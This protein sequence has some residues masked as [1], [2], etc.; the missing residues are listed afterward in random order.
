MNTTAMSAPVQ[1]R[2]GASPAVSTAR[3]RSLP[4][5]PCSARPG[6]L[7]SGPGPHPRCHLHILVQ[8]SAVT[9]SPVQSWDGLWTAQHNHPNSKAGGRCTHAA[10]ALSPSIRTTGRTDP[11]RNRTRP[12][13]PV[14]MSTVLGLLADELRAD[15]ATPA[16]AGMSDL[17]DLEAQADTASIVYQIAD[18]ELAAAREQLAEAQARLDAADA[19]W[20]RAGREM[21]TAR[22]AFGAAR[23]AVRP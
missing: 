9:S 17:A 14:T 3:A 13:P 7:T 22:A 20:V 16:P 5:H 2:A 1:V 11:M 23:Q 12:A 6:W 19:E 21:D 15:L 8:S 4:S 18:R 10:T